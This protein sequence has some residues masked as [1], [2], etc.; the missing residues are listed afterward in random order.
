M[1]E[2]GAD[3]V[4]GFGREDVLELTGLLLDFSFAIHRE[5][6]GEEALG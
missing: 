5:R 2:K 1:I 3:F 6:I 4:G